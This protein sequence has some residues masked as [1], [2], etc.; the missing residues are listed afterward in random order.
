MSVKK[1]NEKV[2]YSPELGELISD[3][4]VRHKMSA[5]LRNEAGMRQSVVDK[6]K[7]GNWRCTQ[8]YVSWPHYVCVPIRKRWKSLSS[9][10]CVACV[11]RKRS[12]FK[13]L[14]TSYEWVSEAEISSSKALIKLRKSKVQNSKFNHRRGRVCLPFYKSSKFNSHSHRHRQS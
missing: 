12:D 14:V 4:I 5:F 7:R 3:A 6:L 9:F 10:A 11:T 8:Q 1:S 13:W 2:F